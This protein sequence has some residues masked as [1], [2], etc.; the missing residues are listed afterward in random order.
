VAIAATNVTYNKFT[1]N[2]NPYID[3]TGW[4]LDVAE[5]DA[6]F[7]P[8]SLIVPNRILGTVHSSVVGVADGVLPSTNYYYRVRVITAGGTSANSNTI[9]VSTPVN[10]CLD[11]NTLIT[12]S[13]GSVKAIKYLS[14]GEEV[15]SYKLG[16]DPSESKTWAGNVSEGQFDKSV[17]K[18]VVKDYVKGYYVINNTLKT[19]PNHMM[20]IQ[21]FTGL[22]RWEG[23]SKI[24]VGYKLFKED[25]TI[26]N[27]DSIMYM[28]AYIN[29]V[30]IDVE[31]TDNYFAGGVL[32]HN[33]KDSS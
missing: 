33:L 17:V 19:T 23:V 12:L 24:L 15:I 22:W 16:N 29:I 7:S 2:W 3:E 32:N 30:K 14:V 26:M 31:Y 18:S 27:V 6:S 5:N 8:G 20:L 25:G 10:P 13:D 28:N 11:E 21:D 4:Q 1:A 9:T